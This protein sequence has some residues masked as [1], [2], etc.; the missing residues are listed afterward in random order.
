MKESGSVM[1]E[2][3]NGGNM[4]ACNGIINISAV[5]YHGENIG[6]GEKQRQSKGGK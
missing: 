1:K 6:N 4:A 5:A 3:G 2:S